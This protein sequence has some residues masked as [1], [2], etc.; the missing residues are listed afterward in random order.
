MEVIIK[1]MDKFKIPI[2]GKDNESINRTIRWQGH[3]YDRLMDIVD[4]HKVSFNR[5]VNECVEFAL[6]RIDNEENGE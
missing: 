2:G 5:L 3:L 1:N 6:D 4:K